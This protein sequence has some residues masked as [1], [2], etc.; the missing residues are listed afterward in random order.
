MIF[1]LMLD[2]FSYTQLLD[3]LPNHSYINEDFYLPNAIS[4][5]KKDS[6][7]LICKSSIFSVII[8]YYPI[9]H[10]IQKKP[11]AL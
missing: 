9:S 10:S 7:N 11:T 4:G 8:N 5:Y 2:S 3:F 6:Q 1:H